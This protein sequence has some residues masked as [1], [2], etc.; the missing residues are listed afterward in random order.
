MQATDSLSASGPGADALAAWLRLAYTPGVSRLAAAR[1]LQAYGTPQ[2]VL[3][4]SLA[5]QGASYSDDDTPRLNAS[6][7]AA[8]RAPLSI[9]PP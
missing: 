4:A 6:Q 8:L 9:T 3:A 5:P 1:L 7:A 2:A